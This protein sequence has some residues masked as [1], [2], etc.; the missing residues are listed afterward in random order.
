MQ[1]GQELYE[2]MFG[3]MPA[4]RVSLSLKVWVSLL[5]P[6]GVLH[7]NYPMSSRKAW[8]RHSVV[9]R[10][11]HGGSHQS[12]VASGSISM[13]VL[14]FKQRVFQEI[15]KNAVRIIQKPNLLMQHVM[16]IFSDL[17]FSYNNLSCTHLLEKIIS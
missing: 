8:Q 3:E 16:P 4:L 6:S 2:K 17:L 11:P 12:A 15:C 9:L 10:L 14:W 5:L 7:F 1:H 13:V